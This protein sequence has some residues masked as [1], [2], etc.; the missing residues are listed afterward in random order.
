MESLVSMLDTVET[1]DKENIL[2]DIYQNLLLNKN[3]LNKAQT[4]FLVLSEIRDISLS[5]GSQ[6]YFDEWGKSP[7]DVN[8][9]KNYVS[10]DICKML[11]KLNQKLYN[12]VDKWIIEN[13]WKFNDE[14][15]DIVKKSF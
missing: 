4:I 14:L 7:I 5:D 8:V 12:D 9:A 1:Y 13:E 11:E 15:A 3:N 2:I 10:A 6:V